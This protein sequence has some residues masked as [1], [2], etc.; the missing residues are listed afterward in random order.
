MN[1]TLSA[2][3]QVQIPQEL[4]DRAQ[5]KSGDTLEV[6]LY[7]GTLVLRKHEALKQLIQLKHSAS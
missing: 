7:Q 4:R 6:H 1:A 3:G 5:L 2:D